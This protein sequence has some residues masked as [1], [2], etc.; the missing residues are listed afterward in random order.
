MSKLHFSFMLAAVK[1][2]EDSFT[3]W[4]LWPLSILIIVAIGNLLKVHI[5]VIHVLILNEKGV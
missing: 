5:Q 4:N 2:K 1:S 3:L